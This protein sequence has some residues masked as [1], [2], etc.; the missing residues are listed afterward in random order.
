MQEMERLKQLY[1][2]LLC[3]T[4]AE[5]ARLTEGDEQGGDEG[6]IV[7]LLAEL[8]KQTKNGE[9]MKSRCVKHAAEHAKELQEL[10]CH[11]GQRKR[12]GNGRNAK[13]G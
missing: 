8:E 2:Q 13:R 5:R 4:E 11:H 1:E 12:D 10:K 6:R 3:D 9:D 7:E